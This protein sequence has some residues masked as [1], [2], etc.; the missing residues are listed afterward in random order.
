MSVRCGLFYLCGVLYG[1]FL[2]LFIFFFWLF[3]LVV[4]YFFFFFLRV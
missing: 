2:D 1:W 3:F 4:L